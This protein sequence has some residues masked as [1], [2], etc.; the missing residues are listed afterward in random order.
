MIEVNG[1]SISESDISTEMQY[2]PAESQRDS[3]IK[4]SESLIITELM[5]QKAES[6][7]VT[8]DDK[9]EYVDQLF[10][11]E[12]PFPKATEVECKVYF[13]QH[14]EKLSTSPLLDAKHIL[15][16]CK[17]DDDTA[18]S[19]AR[20]QAKEILA[21]L[22][23]SPDDFGKLA[24]QYS[25]C[26]SA[27][28]GGSLGQISRGQTVPEF[29]RQVFNCSPGLVKA[30]IESRYGIHIV[31]IQH[32]VEGRQLPYEQVSEKVETYLNDRVRHKAI[33]QYIST[34]I[35][36]ADI[37]GFEFSDADKNLHH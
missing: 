4:A 7:G 16:A 1:T 15:I 19:L 12:V 9:G 6:L 5:K 3:M 11:K 18:R 10:E 2:H 23:A 36:E 31:Y 14:R 37:D 20:I 13:E 24:E 28:V 27:K 22:E 32:R 35:D 30:P 17:K 21:Q 33:A 26:S 34:L 8:T 25:L 29:E